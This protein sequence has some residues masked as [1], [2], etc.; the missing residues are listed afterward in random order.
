MTSKT[1]WFNKGIYRS[2]VKRFAWGSVVYFILLFAM[3]SLVLLLSKNG[4]SPHM[5]NGKVIPLLLTRAFVLPSMLLSMAVPTIVALLIFRFIH[6]KR[7]TIFTHSLPVSRRAN[8]VSSLLAAF[9][10]MAVPVILNGLIL[11]AVAARFGFALFGVGACI[12]WILINLLCLFI[13]FAYACFSASLTGN[14]FA[15]VVINV[16]V[17]SFLLIIV[18]SFGIV[19]DKFLYGYAGTNTIQEFLLHY[20]PL[21]WLVL[22]FCS[23]EAV[24]M[25]HILPLICQITAASVFYV[26][27]Y[28]LYRTRRL[29]TA[30]DV[31][32][33]KCLNPIFKY[34][35]ASLAA[36]GSFAIFNGLIDTTPQL[37]LILILLITV[38]VYT[39]CEMVLKKTLKVSRSYKGLIGFFAVT[40]VIAYVFVFTSFFGFETYVPKTEDIKSVAVYNYY[41]TDEPFMEDSDIKEL[42][43]DV[44]NRLISKRR[45]LNSSDNQHDIT[46][47]VH[48]VYNLSNGKTIRRQYIINTTE[49]LEVMNRVYKNKDYVRKCDA[50]FSSDVV[51]YVNAEITYPTPVSINNAEEVESLMAAVQ[52][53]ILS[54]DYDQMFLR[55]YICY[56]LN[57]EIGYIRK[58]DSPNDDGEGNMMYMNRG[59]NMNYKNTL[60]WLSDHGIDWHFTLGDDKTV[61]VAN[62]PRSLSEGCT[63]NSDECTELSRDD[64]KAFEEYVNS[65]EVREHTDSE[66]VYDLY[67]TSIAGSGNDTDK[68][69]SSYMMRITIPESEVPEW[70]IKYLK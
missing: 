63:L 9:T 62:E 1:S 65:A 14:T 40:A 38:I 21:P 59:I 47:N 61:Y 46:T 8:Y 26:L 16:L 67:V 23:Y 55:A 20:L 6:S 5:I 49:L 28:V 22:T 70:L 27:G 66:K 42:A 11:I 19:A 39:A 25:P 30:D 58:G 35:A 13:A 68:Y 60:K 37:A 53:D 56:D 17:H 64:C 57:L 2:E 48:I 12:Q 7:Q 18:S 24:A 52:K 15:A 54:L 50:F 10:L 32:G 44:Q 36:L 43:V 41:T 33:F 29:E 4:E 51:R 34:F 3:T 31:A 69:L 45:I